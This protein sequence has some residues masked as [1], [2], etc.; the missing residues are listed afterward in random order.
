MIFDHDHD[1]ATSWDDSQTSKDAVP[2]LVPASVSSGESQS[3]YDGCREQEASTAMQPLPKE[4]DAG[5][6]RAVTFGEVSLRSYPVIL[7]DH[8][9]CIG[10][11]VSCLRS[12]QRRAKVSLSD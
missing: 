1:L 8:P 12:G 3:S 6:T 9:D 7:G 5:R 11:P 10:P 2:A 4:I